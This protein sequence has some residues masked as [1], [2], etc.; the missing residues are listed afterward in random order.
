MT[1]RLDVLIQGFPGK[2]TSNVM[3]CGH[4]RLLS[5]ENGEVVHRSELEAGILARLTK[6]FDVEVTVDLASFGQPCS[7]SV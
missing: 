7:T 3:V 4:D 1:Y 5:L 6:E 2:S